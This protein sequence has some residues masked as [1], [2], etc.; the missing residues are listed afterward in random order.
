MADLTPNV[1][2]NWDFYETSSNIYSYMD[3]GWLTATISHAKPLK[4]D[5][6]I[7]VF[8]YF[9]T[10]KGISYAVSFGSSGPSVTISPVDS[11]TSTVV[12]KTFND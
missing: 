11:V 4:G 9:H 12:S 2:V 6:T 3:Y 10:W 7:V 1:G 8:T 5:P